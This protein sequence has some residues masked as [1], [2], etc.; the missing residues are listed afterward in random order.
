[1]EKPGIKSRSFWALMA[2]QFLG[3]ANDNAFQ[4]TV[5]FLILASVTSE[6]AKTAYMAAAGAVFVIP[7]LIFSTFAGNI[8]DRLSKRTVCV[9]SKVAEIVVMALGIAAL[10]SGS[11][12]A[13]LVVLFCMTTQSTFFSPAKYGILPEM[14]EEAELSEGNG[15]IQML[16]DIAIITGMIVGPVLFEVFQRHLYC[17]GVV[18]VG[19]AVVGT[20][21]SLF[22]G[23]VPAADRGRRMQ[24]N[25]IGEMGRNIRQIRR[26]RMLFLCII[27]ESFFWLMAA[28]FK[29][30]FPVYGKSAN[31]LA[32]KSE[33][34]VGVLLALVALGIGFGAFLAGRWSGGKVEFG[35]V[36]IGGVFMAVFV[37]ILFVSWRSAI[38]TGIAVFMLGFGGGLYLIPLATFVQQRAPSDRKGMVL[39]TNNFITFFGVLVA[40]GIYY[41]GASVLEIGPAGIFLAVAVMI[42]LFCAGF[43]RLL[44]EFP[45]RS[46]L[47]LFGRLTCRLR[48]AAIE[49]VPHEGPALLLCNH[50]CGTDSL[51]VSAGIP[52]LVRFVLPQ[53][54]EGGWLARRLALLI[55][56]IQNGGDEGVGLATQ[57]MEADELVGV[58]AEQKG[59]GSGIAEALLNA[60]SDAGAPVIPVHIE[61]APDGGGYRPVVKI[62]F[63]EALPSGAGPAEV[64]R[65]ME[66]LQNVS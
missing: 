3:A 66:E 1:M 29:I 19:V 20:C 6:K 38:A 35:L 47:W 7:F 37:A 51:L 65:A 34:E 57:A 39:A 46:P 58:F 49:R 61:H 11:P 31:L 27:G 4:L 32:L 64:R 60:A 8:A 5:Q 22:V 33:S 10:G 52:R 40:S 15:T 59:H 63:G 18:Y 62:V 26:D 25:F 28:C 36:P 12:T 44:P 55:R 48:A 9:W 14:L 16:T 56:F 23:A 45:L 13:C 43:F 30:N 2:T 53:P 50:V 21:T 24:W 17:A 42:V 41:L 54:M